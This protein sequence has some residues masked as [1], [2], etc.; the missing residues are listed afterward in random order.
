MA[1]AAQRNPILWEYDGE[2]EF[3]ADIPLVGTV[4]VPTWIGNDDI[5][6][7]KIES[8]EIGIR[9]QHGAGL[10]SDVKLFRY[11]IEDHIVTTD[12]TVGLG[13][14]LFVTIP[15]A[16][17]DNDETTEVRGIELALEYS[18]DSML[19]AYGG[20]SLVDADSSLDDLDES[21]PDYTAYAGMAYRFDR[22]HEISAHYYYLDALTWVDSSADLADAKRLDLR[23]AYYRQNRF[24]FEIVGQNLLE[25][26]EDYES[27]NIRDR[28]IYLRISGGF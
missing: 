6:P 15:V 3:S 18:P 25:D 5:E 13:P 20:I 23:Y 2:T 9:S 14:P 22:A 28:V 21:F 7:E 1:S 16:T 19:R 24:K 4:I 10:G 17:S 11:D 12:I 27:E 26:F 8:F